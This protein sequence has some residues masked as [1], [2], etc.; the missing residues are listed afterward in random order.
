M[1]RSFV[2]LPFDKHLADVPRDEALLIVAGTCRRVYH[3]E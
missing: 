2:S 1:S 3:L